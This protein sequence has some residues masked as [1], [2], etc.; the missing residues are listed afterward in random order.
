MTKKEFLSKV[1]DII[2]HKVWGYAELEIVVDSKEQKG[3]CYRLKDKTASCG[4]Y[5]STWNDV[6]ESLNEHLIQ[7]GYVK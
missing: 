3:V 1:P 6:F 2:D 5:G 7:E 4:T